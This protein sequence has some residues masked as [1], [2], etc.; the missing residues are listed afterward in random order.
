MCASAAAPRARSSSTRCRVPTSTSSTT[1]RRRCSTS[2]RPCRELRDVATDQQ[3]AGTTLTLTIDRDQAVALRPDAAGDRRHA[4]RCLR[5]APDRAVFHAAASYHV[6]MEV[7]PA[8][9]GD[10]RDARQDLPA[11]ADDGRRGAA[12]RLRQMD[13]D[14]GPAAVDQPSGPVPGDHH[15]LQPG[16]RDGAR[17]GDRGDRSQAEPSSTCRRPS[18]TTFQGN[19]QAFQDSLS[20]VPMLILAALVVVYLILGILYESYIHPITIL[21]TLAV[22][23]RRRARDADAVRLRFQPDRADRRHPADRHRE[24]E[25]H[26]DGRLRHRGRARP[27]ICPR[28]R[29]SGAPRSCASG[30]S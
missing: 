24:E 5:P 14:P 28:S 30:R 11:L 7:L 10:V 19:A 20:T 18:R 21:S 16:A 3:T 2:S 27:T 6:I 17:P 29:R 15:Q 9:Q 23:R 26:H 1:G 4:L 12:L 22:G 13:D 8:L 25:R